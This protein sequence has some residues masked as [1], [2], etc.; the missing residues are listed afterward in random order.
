MNIY[1]TLRTVV[2]RSYGA[3]QIKFPFIIKNKENRK[4][5]R[6]DSTLS[7]VIQRNHTLPLS[8]GAAKK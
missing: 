8:I 1:S 6:Y 3:M 2:A 5:N 7:V 4:A